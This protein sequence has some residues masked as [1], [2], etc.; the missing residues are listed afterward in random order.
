M[1]SGMEDR[2]NVSQAYYENRVNELRAKINEYYD[3]I[4]AIEKRVGK[5]VTVKELEYMPVVPLEEEAKDHSTST[6][7]R[8]SSGQTS[9]ENSDDQSERS[10]PE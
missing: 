8:H 1:S 10:K 7:P 4:I 2:T 3:N 5:V 6:E 9:V